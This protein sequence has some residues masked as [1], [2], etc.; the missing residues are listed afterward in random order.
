MVRALVSVLLAFALVASASAP[1]RSIRLERSSPPDL[2]DL[3]A[4]RARTEAYQAALRRHQAP[5]V[6]AELSARVGVLI[7]EARVAAG[8]S[9][10]AW[11]RLTSCVL[12]SNEQRQRSS[13]ARERLEAARA[14][15]RQGLA[16]ARVHFSALEEQLRRTGGSEVARARFE[17]ERA[18]LEARAGELEHAMAQVSGALGCDTG[19]VWDRLPGFWQWGRGLGAVDSL[20]SLRNRLGEL[21]VGR[22]PGVLSADLTYVQGRLQASPLATESI[23]PAYQA[24]G[25]PGF[26][27]EDTTLERE[28]EL[29]P[30]ITAKATTLGSARAAYEFVKN[31]LRL[32]WYYGSLKGATETLREGRGNDADLAAL[33]VSLLRAQKTPAR[34]VQGTIE[35][36]I[37]RVADLLGLL[38]QTESQALHSTTPDGPAFN[39]A[40]AKRE[41][42]LAALSGAG[43]PFEPVVSGGQVRAV[44]LSHIWVE[45]YVPYGDYRGAGALRDGRQWVPLDPSIPGGPK[46]VATEP[47]L[48]ALEELGTSAEALTQDYLLHGNGTAPLV[49]WK[50]KVMQHLAGK[51]PSHLYSETQR[52]VEQKSE[53]Q[54]LLPGALPY[55][56]VSVQG[57]YAFL[58]DTLKHRLRVSARDEGGTTLLDVTLPMHLVTGRRAIFTYK[59]A[60][61]E[62]A[63]LI[64][65]A[66]GLYNA[67]ASV[68]EMRAV[69]RVD[70]VERA[71]AE[72]PVGLGVRHGWTL[73]LLLPDG[74]KRQVDNEIIAGN[75]VAIGLGAPFNRQVP[76]TTPSGSGLDGPSALFLFERAA[77]YVNEWTTAEEELALLTR[78]VPVRPTANL[79]L[80]ENQLEVQETFGI[81]QQVA[82]KGLQVDAD[83]RSLTPLELVEGRGAALL[84]LS[85]YQG[86]FLES[87]ILSDG[88]GEK[89]VSAVTLMQEAH[90]KVVPVLRIDQDNVGTELAK[91]QAPP[92]VKTD[93]SDLVTRGREV[94]IPAQPLVIENWTGTGFIA[95]DPLTEEGGYFL[96]GRL[97]GGQTVVS[98]ARW[99]DRA[100]A[101]LLESA[102]APASTNDTS[103]AARII[104]V[105]AT[106][107]QV[108]TVGQVL[109]RALQVFVTTAEGVPVHGA[110]VTFSATGVAKP[111]FRGD[112][113]EQLETLTVQT[114]F[115]GRA[116][117][118]VFP[119]T[120]I[121]KYRVHVPGNPNEEMHG[122]NA[123]T[124]AVV[125]LGE[126]TAKA[127]LG[128]PFQF[129][130]KAG[131]V[132][133]LETNVSNY[134]TDVGV[135]VGIPLEITAKDKYGNPV[136]NRTIRWTS[137]QSAV[138]DS[139]AARFFFPAK[140]R[141]ARVQFL[142]SDP[143][144][145][146]NELP[147]VT[148]TFGRVAAGFIAGMEQ[149]IYQINADHFFPGVPPEDLEVCTP[150]TMPKCMV[151]K[152]FT[153]DAF[154]L[155]E[156]AFRVATADNATRH[157]V[158]NADVPKPFNV[159]ILR[160]TKD[161]PWVRV[162]G[163][164]EDLKSA[165]VT[166][167][168][169]DGK[170][171]LQET[172]TYWP[173]AL[174]T[175]A[176][177]NLDGADNVIFW[178]SYELDN[179]HQQ[180]VF[181][182]KVEKK[183]STASPPCCL[184]E[185]YRTH[186]YS[187]VPEISL[188][189]VSASGTKP[190]D[191]C[192]K[193]T[194]EDKQ[195]LLKITNSADF[196]L[197]VQLHELPDVPGSPLIVVPP[198]SVV[199]RDP[200]SA[201]RLFV[202]PNSMGHIPLEV[203]AST[204]GGTLQ[205]ELHAPDFK[206]SEDARKSIASKSF[207]INRNRGGAS[208]SVE[209]LQASIVLSVRN[210]AAAWTGTGTE[211][212]PTRVPRSVFRPARLPICINEPGQLKVTS[213]GVLVAGAQVQ[214]LAGGELKLTA[215]GET[216]PVPEVVAS[217][218][219][220]ALI[221]PGDPSGQD[222]VMTFDPDAPDMANS[223]QTI[224]LT[225]RVEDASAL[226]VGHTFVK[227][228]STVDG[229]LVKQAVD[230]E[231]QGR[232]PGL[233]LVR[234]Y[235]SRGHD[236]SPL[237]R[238]WSHSYRGYV[239][240]SWSQENNVVRYMVVG[241]EGTGQVFDCNP[242]LTTCTNQ[243]GFHGT[244]SF[245]ETG[246][247][248]AKRRFLVY[249]AKNGT[250]YHYGFDVP[251]NTAGGARY[252]LLSIRATTGST[253]EFEY[254]NA[255]VDFEVRRIYEPGRRR[256]LQ[257]SYE[258]PPG[259]RR[260]QLARVDL[261]LNP[262]A[263][264][265]F[266]AGVDLEPEHLKVCIAYRYNAQSDL[267]SVQRYDDE[268][269]ANPT[270]GRPLRGE[271]FTYVSSAGVEE[272]QNNLSSWTD[273]NGN[274]TTFV[275]YQESD[276]LPGEN[277]YTKF[278]D[279]RERIRYV[280]E[281]E[282]A[283]TE[284]IYSLVR[285]DV[286]VFGNPLKAFVTDVKGPRPDVTRST[287][288][289]MNLDGTAAR[290]ERP[291]N[292]SLT[293]IS[294]SEWDPVH[295]RRIQEEDAR[296]RKTT[297]RYDTFG[298]LIERRTSLAALPASGEG[299][300]TEAVK[301]AN[302]AVLVETVEKWSYDAAFSVPICSMDAEGRITTLTLDSEGA[303]PRSGLVTST[304]LVRS[305]RRYAQLV[306]AAERLGI[307]TCTQLALML[308]Q[309]SQ[310]IEQRRTYCQVGAPSCPQ[311]AIKG[312]LVATWT[313][314]ELNRTDISRYDIW[315]LPDIQRATVKTGS[316]QIET[317]F[318]RNNRGLLERQT[319]TFGHVTT[320][321]YDALDRVKSTARLNGKRADTL[322]LSTPSPAIVQS[323]TYYPGGQLETE[324]NGIAG[325]TR[326]YELDGLNRV[327]VVR[328][329]GGNLSGELVTRYGYDKAGNRTTV[330]DRRGVTTRTKY[331]WGDR[332]IETTVSVAAEGAGTY[333]SQG[334]EL[335]SPSEMVTATF[336][337]DAVGNKV[338]ETDL[339]GRRTDLALDSLYRVV[340]THSPLVP[341]ASFDASPVRYV[342][343]AR[344]DLVG[345]LTKK[346]DGNL[347]TTRMSYDFAN[348]LVLTEDA[349]A[350][351]E[352]REYD[353]NGNLK[354]LKR[355]VS[356]AL[357]LMQTT[358]YDGLNRPLSVEEQYKIP[359]YY[360]ELSKRGTET[361]YADTRNSFTVKDARGFLTTTVKDDADR[362]IR[363][364]V[365]DVAGALSRTPD[366][367][368]GDPLRLTTLRGYDGNG[369]LTAEVDPLGRKTSHEYDGL[370]RR[371]A[372][373]FPMGVDESFTYDGEGF[374][375]ARV[376]GRNVERK[377]SFD[378]LRRP[379]TDK[380]VE[381]LSNSG[382]E[383][384]LLTRTYS[385]TA[386][387]DEL[388]FVKETDARGNAT[389]RYFDALGRELSVVDAK[390]KAQ[391]TR[392]DAVNP[393]EQRDRKNHVTRM[394]YDKVNRLV[395]QEDIAAGTTTVKYSQSILYDDRWPNETHTD[396]RAISLTK[397]KDGLGRVVRT[398]RGS[399]REEMSY[400]AGDQVVAIMDANYHRTRWL[401]DGAGRKVAETR[402]ADDALVAATTT[403]KY[404]AAGNLKERK[405][406]RNTGVSYDE[407]NSFD[408]LDRLVRREDALGNVWLTAYDEV[409]NKV[410]EKRPLGLP[411]ALTDAQIAGM[412]LADLQAAACTGNQVTRYEYDELNKLTAVT[413]ALGGRYTYVYDA[414]RNLVV[415][416]D[417]NANLT[418][419]EYDVL[420][421]R[422][423][424]HQHLDAHA[425]LGAGN[426][427]TVP[428][429][430]LGATP[431]G[432]V[433][434]LTWKWEYDANGNVE[435]QTD[436]KAQVTTSSYELFNRLK[437]RSFS[438]PVAR[439]KPYVERLD[440]EYD[441][442]GNPLF[443]HET[444]QMQSGRVVEITSRTYDRLDRLQTQSRPYG[445]VSKS[446]SYEY[447]A[448]GNRQKITDA[449]GVTTTY[450]YDAL[451]RLK[452]A[453][454]AEGTT[455]YHYWPDSLLKSSTQPNG[456]REGRCYDKV[457]QLEKQ[458]TAL[459][460]V[461][462]TC[463][464]AAATKILSR[465]VYGYDANGNRRSLKESRTNP[466]TQALRSEEQTA[467]GY[468][469]L[470]R[471]LWT[472]TPEQ[473]AILYKLDGVG[474]RVGEREAPWDFVAPLIELPDV[475]TAVPDSS[476]SRDVTY[477][478][479]RADWQRASADAK[480]ST[481]N[482]TFGYDL[483]GNLVSKV[484][485]GIERKFAWDVRNTLTTIFDGAVEV[486]RYDYNANLQ[487]VK[488]DTASEHVAY[489]LDEDFVLNELDA[490][491][492]NHPTKRRY[493]YANG[494]L[495][496]S[497][498]SGGTN[499]R[500]LNTD[501]LGSVTD[502]TS[503][504]GAVST[505]RQYDAWGGNRGGTAPL[506]S[507]PKLGYTG[508]QHD[509]ETG[510]T[511]ARARYY[512]SELGRFISRDSHEGTL[513]D[514]PSLNRYAYTHGN[515]L[516]YV[517]PDG[518][519]IAGPCG[520]QSASPQCHIV[521]KELGVSGAS[522]V[523][524]TVKVAATTAVTT[525]APA[526][527]G[528]VTTG[529]ATATD[530]LLVGGGVT[531]ALGAGISTYYDYK[532]AEL[533]NQ[534]KHSQLLRSACSSGDRSACHTVNYRVEHGFDDGPLVEVAAAGEQTVV[535]RRDAPGATG[536]ARSDPS[537]TGAT[538]PRSAPGASSGSAS[539]PG[540]SEGN[541]SAPGVDSNTDVVLVAAKRGPKPWPYGP[542]NRTI[543]RR[544]NEL[545]KKLGP[546]WEHVGGGPYVEITI[547]IDAPNANKGSRRMDIAFKNVK[548]GEFYY[549]NVGKIKPNGQPVDREE[550]A[551]DDVEAQRG[552]RPGFTPYNVDKNGRYVPDKMLKKDDDSGAIDGAGVVRR[553]KQFNNLKNMRINRPEKEG[554]Q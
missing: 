201:S 103:L 305:T 152:K 497:D 418:T 115:S 526:A 484:K 165:T 215:L 237:G 299:G 354:L 503:S 326:S 478:F 500:H 199:R 4:V 213:G 339:Y 309:S 373:H 104:K 357:L 508:H 487:R 29:S 22:S 515:P 468:D 106:D 33:L 482:V 161:N 375:V 337:Y 153:V 513:T 419:Y 85:G 550:S 525:G 529:G 182:A 411:P 553:V 97:S 105:P 343:Q 227:D 523:E 78:V 459:G 404:D 532:E 479:N 371:M 18:R 528:V 128:E 547:E 233:Q 463:D 293:A 36:P 167:K 390:N 1:P 197:Y 234:S 89:A 116:R 372:T 132:E 352:T 61:A 150:E 520:S 226:P 230:L 49:F 516:R 415:K 504:S 174:G 349:V 38:E 203:S 24:A 269:P 408:A 228:V 359:G 492:A 133:K 273:A 92:E 282:G 324:K 277:D 432:E 502:V 538:N 26:E 363:V 353:R 66:G 185:S 358:T 384:A 396:R 205:V 314:G 483:N 289:Y 72:R 21:G 189:E 551:L 64:Y 12:M 126:E 333:A 124:A 243:N 206:V 392:F 202:P 541:Q 444:K 460:A 311:N 440:F 255:A 271:S 362:V 151:R 344:Y 336:G 313:E 295:V 142:G 168:S 549:E 173:H 79:V 338:Y 319:D 412:S 265:P 389:W 281:P 443:V 481:R 346:T 450:T 332:P 82:F 120:D 220:S 198:P 114:D 191:A 101:E 17:T 474:N 514:A 457:G 278:G 240:P 442:N 163:K 102:D 81:R 224:P 157:G 37:G 530:A 410:C 208:T 23:T 135:E 143:A 235:T 386:S 264:E 40:V 401:Y 377:F 306:P 160:R 381:R 382:A 231:V 122:L 552:V 395:A 369:N 453:T 194:T 244:F 159:E 186:F 498:I 437:W 11:R 302:E 27:L 485:D 527:V 280:H 57:E 458:V 156:F 176:T 476:L 493:H 107:L 489:V 245:K 210:F 15:A 129:T 137:D 86:S 31:E 434:T 531:T 219:L 211:V 193:A 52:T 367:S 246:T 272:L 399:W 518:H 87:K 323:F 200:T 335:P 537:P 301:D 10:A 405:G 424:E 43:I 276:P 446:I 154:G 144:A 451:D 296:G 379:V 47:A 188:D 59:P 533:K 292:E 542:H 32:D 34:F 472:R 14:A 356:G 100:L 284:F 366:A 436:P 127:Q 134:D 95:R 433:G 2:A 70:G 402:G 51:V 509:P 171:H 394:R 145:Q 119:D 287:R 111:K 417:A 247:G 321:V 466:A 303:D 91:V 510:L 229:H 475:Y 267:E 170:G 427:N 507:E 423:A 391:A 155:A 259:A 196:P 407:R 212:P 480:N 327:E 45:A 554:I 310:D 48:D 465:F 39:L 112:F 490:S 232:G 223:A 236:A 190:V 6:S 73:E 172:K 355:L 348:R 96:S 397:D 221:P 118:E 438:S 543:Q 428:L 263:P 136:P 488:R 455:E 420:N 329:S 63:E 177:A 368:V 345:N 53:V 328:E 534:D 454:L 175:G 439:A 148:S 398:S 88:I 242:G 456:V 35:L 429:E 217:G 75:M 252:P 461:E 62:D 546:D 179:D 512:D 241:G 146:K 270:S 261:Y 77:A 254:G 258:R 471:L 68:V 158:R 248:D 318:F 300:A 251:V 334:G 16:E 123:V 517:D 181:S 138:N 316:P 54:P 288:Y 183:S 486:G 380:L 501:A 376:D 320:W 121:V 414:A 178:P 207:Q 69:L 131:P 351:M 58:P 99:T 214:F 216:V 166:I 192:G 162:T 257:F 511:Y 431:E 290:V 413:D 9:P 108:G 8:E 253:L 94:L 469:A 426:R 499:T 416:Q 425:R 494:P 388:A 256:F 506:A 3:E 307:K 164:E 342:S 71:V 312:D 90:A 540:A 274:T 67:P 169:Y 195:L 522:T 304:G 477:S 545:K 42:A 268:C 470:D 491:Q 65:S 322:H 341:G 473:N 260:A 20:E 209:R 222:V 218:S 28:V 331:D 140:D 187:A 448:K 285:A 184:E 403:Y 139:N 393:R 340:A 521:M 41:L 325:F 505:M 347:H 74:S 374:L 421:L 294:S 5:T 430:E 110:S 19:S 83:L 125:M 447:Y 467:Y 524:G 76:P 279:K 535:E 286:Q 298:N 93:V 544:I 141:T 84:R 548:T 56:V 330:T 225:T 378:M 283:T 387:P 13:T 147:T 462:D 308:S 60:S 370:N 80:V 239:L 238:G 350:R 250:E 495:A 519:Q 266:P 130:A 435:S 262:K 44:K 180:Y 409:G 536:V 204:S 297:F 385:D 422:R 113:D 464:V 539:A 50:N 445:G 7:D 441:E 98:P 117:A 365:D 360:T 496:V 449:D 452:T 249:R 406:P 383:L 149:R 30:E 275:Y 55:R 317:Q 364:V 291:L 25:T 46:Y 400:N 361:N 315:G 109:P